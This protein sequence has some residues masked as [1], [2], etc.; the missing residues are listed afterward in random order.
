M[1]NYRIMY[2]PKIG[3]KFEISHDNITW[4]KPKEL[5]EDQYTF[6]VNQDMPMAMGLESAKK[7]AFA[8]TKTAAEKYINENDDS[9][10]E[11]LADPF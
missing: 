5:S 9:W 2:S 4:T 1:M 10:H 6:K 8:K 3:Y 11:V 7:G